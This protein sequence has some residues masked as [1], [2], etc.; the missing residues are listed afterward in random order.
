MLFKDYTIRMVMT[1]CNPFTEK[2][3]A[4][5][6]LKEDIGD[7]LPYLNTALKG[8]SYNDSEKTLVIKRKGH[9]IT[10]RPLQIAITKLED[11]NEARVVMEELRE[12]INDTFKR[13]D[14]IIPSYVTGSAPQ[15]LQV[16]KLLPGKNC[17]ECGEQSCFAFAF[18]L[19]SGERNI[20]ECPLIFQ[21]EYKDRLVELGEY[22]PYEERILDGTDI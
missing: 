13:R 14:E 2:L 3:N 15:P 20:D 19:L 16:Y 4:I 21:D 5:V 17:K 12:I 11:E 1:E 7:A 22:F 8:Y 18:K 10:I 6:E 9:L